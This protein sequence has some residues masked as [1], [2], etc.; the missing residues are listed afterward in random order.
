L[1]H[2]LFGI[3]PSEG[4]SG[5]NPD[6]ADPGHVRAPKEVIKVVGVGGGGGNALAHMIGL[7]LSGV[8]TVVANTDVRAMEM[9]DAQV[10]I[11]LGRELTKGLGAGANPE[12][13]HKAAV[14]SREE[15]RRVLEGS[16]MVYF[17]AGMGG[18][19][20]TGALPVMAAMAREMG[21]LTVAVVT[22]PFTFEGAKRMNNALAGIREL[23]PA[24][25]SLIVI[26]NDRLIEISDAR[27]TIQ[28]SFAMAND[29]L[30]Q[31]VQ[32][33]TDLIVRPGLVNVDFADVRAVMRCAGRAVMGIGSARG[34]DRAKEALR[35][36][37]ESPLMEV[38]LKDARGG[39][40]NVTAGPDIGIHEIHEAAEAFQSYLGEDALFFWGYGED[41]DLTGTVKVVVIAAGFDGE[42]R[43]DAP[44]K[45]APRPRGAEAEPLRPP[46]TPDRGDSPGLFDRSP[47]SLDVPTILRRRGM[48]P[49]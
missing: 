48:G 2:P 5:G 33:V 28:E 4:R 8:T 17:A 29:V 37:M 3:V 1:A 49:G 35:R 36:A 38:R 12:V 39:L 6:G 7:G 11:V 34:E 24:V 22:K 19:T 45:G 10:K 41:P 13:G 20:G 31:A 43:C 40:I 42:D 9:V 47:S 46:M 26:P 14:E 27:M 23:E 32:G 16:D 18:G 25:D 30:R 44:P 15:I 21:I